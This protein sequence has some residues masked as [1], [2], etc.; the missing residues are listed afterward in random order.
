MG[1]FSGKLLQANFSFCQGHASK[2]VFGNELLVFGL[3]VQPVSFGVVLP[4][5]LLC[6]VGSFSR[7][8]L[9]IVSFGYVVFRGGFWRASS[10]CVGFVVRI[11]VYSVSSG[12]LTCKSPWP[13]LKIIICRK[14]CRKTQIADAN[15]KGAVKISTEKERKPQKI[16][17]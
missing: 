2:A 6:C 12:V 15:L 9:D 10:H 13:F 16:G 1:L 17:R 4:V 11:G 8:C 14:L 7:S 3:C 5:F